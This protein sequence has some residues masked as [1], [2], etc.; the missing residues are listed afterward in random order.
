MIKAQNKTT[1][2]S[3]PVSAFISIVLALFIYSLSL[4]AC[5]KNFPQARLET[6]DSKMDLL[7]AG[8]SSDFR[9][10]IKERLIDRYT[11]KGNIEVT[12]LDDL[13]N[14]HCED[15]DAILVMDQCKASGFFNLA[16]K[17]F[18]T[19]SSGCNNIVVLM[20]AGDADWKY[21]YDGLDAITSASM[22]MNEDRV[23]DEISLKIDGLFSAN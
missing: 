3:I 16:L 5:A 14:I 12:G 4:L 20:T 7:I 18:L 15:Y 22:I 6:P 19:R 21:R 10:S 1:P 11:G 9:D 2:K 8:I 17:S 23:F 13:Q